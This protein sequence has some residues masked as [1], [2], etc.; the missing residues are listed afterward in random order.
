MYQDFVGYSEGD[1]KDKKKQIKDQKDVK[2]GVLKVLVMRAK[3]LRAADRDTSDPYCCIR[4]ENY[5]KPLTLKTKYINKTI[6]PEWFEMLKFYVEFYKDGP[7]PPLN[8]EVLDY[9][10]L[11][12]DD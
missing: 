2:R 5:D 11:S 8:V 1:I 7:F 3:N 4:F 10:T 6:N 12:K 9:D